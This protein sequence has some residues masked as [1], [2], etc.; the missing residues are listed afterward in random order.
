M[1]TFAT[2]RDEHV[3]PG[4][5]AAWRRWLTAH[6]GRAAG[7]WVVLDRGGARGRLDYAGLVEEALCFGWIDSRPGALDDAHTRLWCAPRRPGSRWSRLNRRRAEALIASGR[8]AAPGLARIE[9]AKRDGT[10]TA[11]D[12]VEDGQL[13]DDLRRA[14]RRVAGATKYFAAFPRSTTRA[15]L[16][17]IAAAKTPGTRAK[18]IAETARLAG[19]NV[20]ANQWRQPKSAGTAPKKAARRRAA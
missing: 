19:R 9:A 18:R 2:L 8:M 14:L 15:I 13:P 11:L 4:T 7:L 17:W 3:Y 20:R 16:E 5:R 10:W 12:A 6:H 1:K